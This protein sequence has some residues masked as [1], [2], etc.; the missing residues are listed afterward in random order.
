MIIEVPLQV[1]TEV[2]NVISWAAKMGVKV[3]WMDE[4]L[5]KIARKKEHVDLMKR[6][7]DLI[8]ELKQLDRRRDGITQ[9]LAETSTELCIIILVFNMP[10][11]IL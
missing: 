4:T 6:S 10:T 5:G 7:R 2:A 9:I 8:K 11:V 3:N 1:L